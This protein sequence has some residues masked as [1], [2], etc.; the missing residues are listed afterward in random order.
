VRPFCALVKVFEHVVVKEIDAAQ[1]GEWMLN[2]AF[3]IA[4]QSSDEQI[5]CGPLL[6]SV[7]L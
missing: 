2:S 3:G 6:S 7:A 4:V 1:L 5:G